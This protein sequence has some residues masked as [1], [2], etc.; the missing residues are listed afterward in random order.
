M[1]EMVAAAEVAFEDGE[2]FCAAVA[3]L[4]DHRSLGF[5]E[6]PILDLVTGRFA[7]RLHLLV[8]PQF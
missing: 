8:P 3:V 4:H 2:I 5:V 6:G 1:S 7:A